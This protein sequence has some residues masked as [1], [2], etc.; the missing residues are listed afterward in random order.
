MEPEEKGV[1]SPG[2]ELANSI[3]HGIGF[4]I[5]IA[6]IW[7]IIFVWFIGYNRPD[8]NENKYRHYSSYI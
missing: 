3:T 7:N 5:G 4:F 6:S 8:S 1:Y 2:E